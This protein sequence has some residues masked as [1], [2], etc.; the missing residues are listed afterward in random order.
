[1]QCFENCQIYWWAKEHGLR[2]GDGFE[3]QLPDLPVLSHRPCANGRRSGAEGTAAEDLLQQIGTWDEC[4][5]LV[6]EWGVWPSGEDW[7]GFYSW[8]GALGERRSLNVAPGHHFDSNER[9]LL[10]H[11][12]M[13]IMEN[14]WDA[15]ILCSRGGLA[16]IVRAKISHDE[17][18]EVLAS[19]A[20]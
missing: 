20:G 18:Y 12:L 16:G 19:S 11:L 7:P 17:Y 4:L 3:V 13:L 14:A 15:N 10:V 8:R 2:C 6:A 5:V 9:E 1:M